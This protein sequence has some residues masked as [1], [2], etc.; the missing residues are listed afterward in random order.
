MADEFQLGKY[1]QSGLLLVYSEREDIQLD[2]E[3]QRLSGI[4][5]KEKRQLLIDSLINGFDVPK[6][7]FHEFVPPKMI[8]GKKYR[9]AIVDG[10][11]RLQTIWDFIDGNLALDDDFRFLR[12]PSIAAGGLHYA[13]LAKKYPKLKTRFDA[14]TLD[15]VTIRTDD[16]ALIEDMFSRLNEAV[17]LN[18]PEKRNAFGGPMPKAIKEVSA[19]LFFTKHIPFQDK[20][21]RH[22]DLAAKFLYIEHS[23]GIVNTK[24]PDLDQFV[25][26][27]KKWRGEG[28]SKATDEAVNALKA[29]TRKTLAA[30]TSTF[31]KSDSLLSQVGMVTLYYHL[32]R[33]IGEGKVA[34]VTRA[35]LKGF[36]KEREKNRDRASQTSEVDESVNSRLLE[37]DSHSQTPNDAYAIK[38]RLNILLHWLRSH[39]QLKYD[40]QVGQLLA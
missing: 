6:L 25:R 28:S 18:A 5:T 38:S 39:H 1:P 16:I 27:F 37:F 35:M 8:S 22:R 11:Q 21:Y 20:R 40:K 31:S 33:L 19:H 9:Y 15:I 36:E 3:Y 24:K 7:Y 30:M 10:K 4:W 14:T 13:E 2:P 12:D 26:N 32:F 23:G 29:A 17:P 34:L